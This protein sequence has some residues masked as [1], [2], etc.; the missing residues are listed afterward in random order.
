MNIQNQVQDAINKEQELMLKIFVATFERTITR[1]HEKKDPV[2]KYS[3]IVDKFHLLVDIITSMLQL[4]NISL[5]EQTQL[6]IKN[7]INM[8]HTDLDAL[9]EW[10]HAPIYAPNHPFC[11][12]ELKK[13]FENEI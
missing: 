1:Y 8:L 7:I 4:K 13:D 3:L 9:E 5:N 11:K 2:I 10:V 6:A 12:I